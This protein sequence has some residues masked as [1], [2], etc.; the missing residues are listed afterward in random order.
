MR[1]SIFVLTFALGILLVGSLGFSGTTAQPLLLPGDTDHDGVPDAID[2]CP[3]VNASFFDRNGDGCID[4]GAGA[5]H[6]E[7]WAKSQMPFTYYINADGVPGI[8]NGSDFTAV[9]NGMNAWPAIPNVVFSVAYAGTSAQQVA[10]ALDRVNLVTFRDSQWPTYQVSDLVLA[11]GISTSFTVDSTYEGVFYRPGQ[12]VDADL[13]FNPNRAFKTPTDGNGGYDIQ[14]IV[15]HEAGHLFG[16]SHSPVQTSTMFYVLPAGTDATS[17]STEDREIFFKAYGDSTLLANSNRIA[18]VVSDGKTSNPVPG[19]IVYAIDAFSNQADTVAA[20]YTLPDGSYAFPGLSDGSYYIAIHPIDGSAEIGYLGKGYVNALVDTTAVTNFASEYYDASESSTDNPA[21]KLAVSVSGGTKATGVDILTN[22]DATPPEVVSIT[23]ANSSS[24]V[25]TDGVI[26]I[27]FSERIDYTTVTGNFV[28]LDEATSTYVTGTASFLKEDSV[29]AFTP[30]APFDFS[31]SYELTLKTGLKDVSGNGLAAQYT[32]SFTTETMPPLAITSLAPSKGVVGSIVVINGAGFSPNVAENAVLFGGTQAEV[33]DIFQNRLL[34]KVPN[35]ATTG[36]V[37][38]QVGANTSNGLTFTVLSQEEVAKGFQTGIAELLA[39]PRAIAVLPGGIWAY[40]AT[41]AGVSAVV[42]DPGFAG[43][44]TVTPIAVSGGLD[45][46]SP[47]PDGKKVYGVSRANERL[48]AIDTDP[49]HGPLFNTIITERPMEV[50]PLGI[51]IDPSG[52]RAYIPADNGDIQ[53]WDVRTGSA[54]FEEQIGLIT[55][56]DGS[57]RGRMAIDP[58]GRYLLAPSGTGKLYVYRVGPDTVFATASVLSDPQDV[59]VDPTGQHA[60]VADGTGN[61]SIVPLSGL[62]KKSY[63]IGTG[64]SLRGMTITPGGSY[65]YVCNRDLNFID[66]IDINEQSSKAR[67]VV[68]TIDLEGN[69]VDIDLTPDGF[70]AFTV[71]QG[72]RQ[73]VVTTI[74][75]GPTLK[76]IS[77]RAGPPGT[78]LVLAGSGFGTTLADIR[79]VFPQILQGPPLEIMPEYSS[80]TSL[81]VTVPVNAGSGPVKIVVTDHSAAD[82]VP[83]VSNSLYFQVISFLTTPGP[84]R[85]AARTAMPAGGSTFMPVLELSPTGDFLVVSGE[86][87]N[88]A[89]LLNVFDTDPESSTFNQFIKS[90]S[91]NDDY[92]PSYLALTPDGE[93]AYLAYSA[94]TGISCYN[95][96][97]HSGTFGKQVGWIDL[98]GRSISR[99]RDM[100]VSPDG[101]MLLV[102]CGFVNDEDSVYVFDIIPGSTRE[103]TIVGALGGIAAYDIAFHPGGRYAYI[104]NPSAEKVD[105]LCLDQTSADYL[106]VVS[107]IDVHAGF[108]RNPQS[109]DFEPDGSRCLI[110]ADQSD[111]K[112]Y[113]V[114]AVNTLSPGEPIIE[115]A[116]NLDVLNYPGMGTRLRVS[117]RGDRALVAVA[118]SANGYYSIDLTADP[119][120]V[121]DVVFD[122]SLNNLVDFDFTPDGTRVYV[123]PYRDSLFIYDFNA[124]SFLVRVSGDEQSGIVSQQLSAP[125]RVFVGLAD[126]GMV[127]VPGVP[128]TFTVTTGGGYFS[129]SHLASQI[130]ATDPGGF[131][132]IN[133]TLGPVVGAQTQRVQVTSIGLI[134]SPMQFIADSYDSPDNLP[135][136]LAQ[137]IPTSGATN[138]SVTSSVQ[139]TFTRAV[140][141]DSITSRSFFVARKDNS[142]PI[143]ALTGFAGG[144]GKV[145]LIPKAALE[146]GTQYEIVTTGGIRDM[147]DGQL[148][149]PGTTE[150]T[151]AAKPPL[152]LAAVTPPSASVGASLVLSGVGFDATASNDKVL[153]NAMAVVPYEAGVNYMKVAVPLNAIPGNVRVV[154]GS[155]TS[156]AVPFVVL[157]PSTSPVDEVLATVNTNS[158]VKSVAVTPDGALAYSVSP[159]G[160]I[161]IPIDV[162]GQTT[163]PSIA[164][165]DDP[166]AIAI[167]GDGRYAYIANFNSGTVSVIVVDPDSVNTFNKVV[168]TITVGTNPL[169]VAVSPDGGRVYVANAGSMNLSVIDGDNESATCHQVLATV[170]TNNTVKSVTVTPDGTRI[171]AGTDVG[172]VVIDAQMNAVTATVNTNN[173]IKSVAV[174]PD[175]AFLIALTTEGKV[176]VID[177][178][179]GSSTVNTVLATISTNNTVKSVAVSPDGALLYLIL[180]SGDQALVYSLTVIGSAAVLEPGTPVPP[181]VVQLAPVD[182]IPTGHDPT[183]IAF[184]R[185]GSGYAFIC[186]AGDNTITILNATGLP[187]GPVAA[188]ITVT[189]RTLNLQSRGRWVTGNIEPPLGYWPEEI[190]LGSVLL[191]GAIPAVPGQEEIEDSDNDGLRELVLKFDRAAFQA[192]LPQ[193]EYIPVT[194]SWTARNRQFF[195]CDTIRT[196]RPVVTHP[197]GG[198]L[199]MGEQTKITWT[200]PA[201]YRVDTVSVHW[202]PDDG[203]SW[204]TL[205][206]GMPDTHA[207]PWRAPTTAHE[208]CLVMVTLFSKGEILGMG[209]S[210][211]PFIIN[212]P[213]AVTIQQ[214]S[215]ALTDGAA[216]LTWSTILEQ[217]VDG[218]NLLRSEKES[219][220]YEPVNAALIA[221]KGARGGSYEFKDAGVSLNRTYYYELEEVSGQGS[222]VVF[223]PY[224]LV[225]RARF[226]LGQNAPNPFNPV[227]TIRFTIPEDSRAR[228]VVYDALGRK[229]R[230]LIDE[231]L[232]ASFYTVQWDG[233][234]DGGRM[235]ASGVYFYRL[236]A[237]RHVQAK[238]ML[239]LR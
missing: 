151:T 125:L 182:T 218:F 164:V 26:K 126:S 57:I 128:V 54:T 87:Q 223:G 35:G 13:I 156:N 64:G 88:T 209:M 227:T 104:S 107:S 24:S 118:G 194:I 150:F 45:A 53:V 79:V 47:T 25:S 205:A 89:G 228:L 135:L 187:P 167:D 237:G 123:A 65:L 180:D 96:N 138:V 109:L 82:P 18:G 10:A 115:N 71:A 100:S 3:A 97:R 14:S 8:T 239:L 27:T 232:R 111:I 23:P 74:G 12:I 62:F 224:S 131:A 170:S 72:T 231:D 127:G 210:Q 56:P 43:Y 22:V 219:E 132:E 141:P 110:V 33:T 145:S 19:A 230:T 215:G 214:F 86:A 98:G 161:V 113:Q 120:S 68:A 85:L 192:I 32:S 159:D 29:I 59:V 201:G 199:A 119:D 2:N 75:L 143:P 122:N 28:L 31:T 124:A 188:E 77:R 233:R 207:L 133:W 101:E 171:Y 99:I 175:G 117:P 66:V 183:F 176:L 129:D 142:V 139:G 73:L 184:D 158:T 136:R 6:T 9:Q 220:G 200:S 162:D 93:R 146:Y 130:V 213:V 226:E 20:D 67:S 140:N 234:N 38:V 84:L 17:L 91:V 83:Q 221:S 153:F 15:T 48:Y 225:A 174:T 149:N 189:P 208:K 1:R 69:P 61:V 236:Q 60:Y 172:Y 169:D 229:V 193:G 55:P 235:A 178:M 155:D 39:T 166:L 195:G 196:I 197:N 177:I 114:I 81:T 106:Q 11:L 238:K 46:L 52:S 50:A 103:N 5:R 105:V 37:T 112:Q 94:V 190:V 102:G 16:I 92:I 116:L 41:D 90:V 198:V 137:M 181:P 51:V 212:A 36:L 179:P 58:S 191:Q 78:K 165:G 21:D 202:S 49:S 163:Y 160:D 108:M 7:F 42:V 147:S 121:A 40:V 206:H 211:Q 185:S 95:V 154:V 152:G 70:Y 44:L 144:N 134:N 34:V 76:S 186:N 217:S 63:D 148:I 173:S 216:V 222:R 168:A 30:G 157:V 203:T 204:I 80:G 4:D